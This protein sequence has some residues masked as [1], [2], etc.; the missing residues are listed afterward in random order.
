MGP[1]LIGEYYLRSATS[2]LLRMATPI[3]RPAMKRSRSANENTN[4]VRHLTLIRGEIKEIAET[5]I[6]IM[7]LQ[8][9]VNLSNR[10]LIVLQLNS[11]NAVSS[12][13]GTSARL[14]I[15]KLLFSTHSKV[16]L[17]N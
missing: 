9:T 10:Y 8:Y 7:K 1:P 17:N 16:T 14:F 15:D 2:D 11:Y 4:R 5:L 13:N 3:A 6:E 12:N